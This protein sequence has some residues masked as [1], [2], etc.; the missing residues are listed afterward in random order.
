MDLI[1]G[2]RER[3]GC[4]LP[5]NGL[6]FRSRYGRGSERD[7]VGMTKRKTKGFKK[8]KGVSQDVTRKR[9]FREECLGLHQLW[10]DESPVDCLSGTKVYTNEQLTEGWR[11]YYM[12]EHCPWYKE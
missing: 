11:P 4:S 12:P 1:L 8:D 7:E 5:E 10:S 3:I 6:G 9:I 2:L